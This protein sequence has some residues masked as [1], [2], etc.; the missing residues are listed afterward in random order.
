MSQVVKFIAGKWLTSKGDL[1]APDSRMRLLASIVSSLVSS[2]LHLATYNIIRMLL[3]Y[4]LSYFKLTLCKQQ[5][6]TVHQAHAKMEELARRL[7]TITSV[8]AKLDTW[9][10]TVKVKETYFT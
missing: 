5:N 9:V 10:T 7:K 2:K 3:N 4:A 8:N 1:G 6:C